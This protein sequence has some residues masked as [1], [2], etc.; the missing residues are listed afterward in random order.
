MVE[1]KRATPKILGTETGVFESNNLKANSNFQINKNKR[2]NNFK[3]Y[4]RKYSMGNKRC[5]GSNERDIFLPP[6]I[7]NEKPF[8]VSQNSTENEREDESSS[9]H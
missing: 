5:S 8:A 3:T 7:N 2:Q 6:R 4:A 9:V 1:W